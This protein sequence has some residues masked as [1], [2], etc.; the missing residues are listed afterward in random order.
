MI[1]KYMYIYIFATVDIRK[2]TFR[3]KKYHKELPAPQKRSSYKFGNILL[4][5]II[6]KKKIML[7]SCTIPACT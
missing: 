5:V 2:S 1:Y 4:N 7:P 3:K 6:I